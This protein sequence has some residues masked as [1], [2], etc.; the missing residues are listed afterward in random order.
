MDQPIYHTNRP[1][2]VWVRHLHARPLQPCVFKVDYVLEQAGNREFG[3]VFVNEKENAARSL[4]AAGLAKVRPPS[5]KQ[6]PFYDELAKAQA[7]A[8]A[9]GLGLH[10]K[11]KDE[12]SAAVRDTP[13][14]DG[15]LCGHGAAGCLARCG[16][17]TAWC[18]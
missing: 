2:L 6:S 10:T 13:L 3:T 9:R 14:A 17:H 8:E 11:D 15:A 16:L 1:M 12:A 18:W 7:D 4:V 5:D